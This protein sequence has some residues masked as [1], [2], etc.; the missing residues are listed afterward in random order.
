LL[1]V[2]SN[3]ADRKIVVSW[4]TYKNAQQIGLISSAT[5]PT[6]ATSIDVPMFITR[7]AQFGSAFNPANVVVERWGTVRFGFQ[8]CNDATAAYTQTGGESG[9]LQLQRILSQIDGLSCP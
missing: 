4:Y 9:T 3:G 5:L 1:A 7:G 8:G 2:G 6:G